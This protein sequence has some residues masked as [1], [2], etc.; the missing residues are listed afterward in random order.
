MTASLSSS[1][2]IGFGMKPTA[3]FFTQAS[4]RS[5]SEEI[6]ITGIFERV[7]SA[8]SRSSTWSPLITGIER[9]SRIPSG[10]SSA[11]LRSASAPS[12]AVLQR[13]SPASAAFS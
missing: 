9:S 8:L 3:P 7:L 11:A 1:A 13:Y 4:P 5:R 10:L 12:E 6:T 2:L